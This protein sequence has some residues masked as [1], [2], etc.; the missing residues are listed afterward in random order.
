VQP[1]KMRLTCTG[2]RPLLMHNER[3]AS[4]LNPYT[5]KI[6]ALT[7]VRKKTEDQLWQIAR[8]EFE[9]GMYWDP[10]AGPYIPANM[11]RKCLIT[12]ARL[13]RAGKKIERGVA[14]TDFMLPLV[15]EGPRDIEGLWGGGKSPFVDMRPVKMK[16]GSR[17]DRCRPVFKDWLIE[18]EV[19]TDPEVIDTDQFAEIA[20]LAGEMQGIGDY[21]EMYGRFS[22]RVE[23]L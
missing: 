21:R 4:Q 23:T 14:V 9:G 5:Q 7:V 13:I 18:A 22:A 1:V 17:I 10:Q 2:T 3:L 11:L 15:Y 20:R 19:I 16:G 6:S 12:G 8:L